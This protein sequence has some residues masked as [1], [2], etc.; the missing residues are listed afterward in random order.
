MGSKHAWASRRLVGVDFIPL[1]MARLASPCS[2][3]IC[4]NRPTDPVLC[5]KPR[6]LVG[7]VYQ[8][9]RASVIFGMVTELILVETFV[10]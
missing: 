1:T 3:C 7:G 5:Q 8:M 10:S 6:G 9:S 2:F 4:H